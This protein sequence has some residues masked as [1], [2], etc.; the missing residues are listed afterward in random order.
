VNAPAFRGEKERL[1]ALRVP[2]RGAAVVTRP[3]EGTE[4]TR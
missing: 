3:A 2:G 1:V 4:P